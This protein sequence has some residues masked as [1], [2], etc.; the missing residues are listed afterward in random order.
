MPD[1]APRPEEG[2]VGDKVSPRLP[3]G[4]HDSVWPRN[5]GSLSLI[6]HGPRPRK[7]LRERTLRGMVPEF[8]LA[9]FALFP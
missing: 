5:S 6:A 4:D 1:T 9:G 7:V 3:A 8:Y 2:T